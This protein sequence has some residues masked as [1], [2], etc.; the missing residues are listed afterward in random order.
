VGGCLR[1]ECGVGGTRVEAIVPLRTGG[2]NG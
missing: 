1:I 2:L